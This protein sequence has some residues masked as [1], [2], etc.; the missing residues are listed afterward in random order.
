MEDIDI[1]GKEVTNVVTSPSSKHLLEITENAI[2][3]DE[4]RGEVFHTVTEK[5]LYVTN[6]A[7]PDIY[8][9]VMFVCTRVSFNDKDY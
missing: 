8:P 6:R 9:A 4:H 5:L 2:H 7:Q 1:F 3:L